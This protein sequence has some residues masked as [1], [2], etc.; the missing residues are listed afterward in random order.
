MR[1]LSLNCGETSGQLSLYPDK[2]VWS[3]DR[4]GFRKPTWWVL[5]VKPCYL[6]VVRITNPLTMPVE[7]L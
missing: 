3:A 6:D 5:R 2:G 7:G 4:V 1:G